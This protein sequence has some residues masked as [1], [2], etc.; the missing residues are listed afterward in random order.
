MKDLTH[1]DAENLWKT[2][3][4]NGNG[5]LSLAEI[6][7]AIIQS[8][9]QYA[10]RKP[11]IMRAYKATDASKDGFVDRKEFGRLM[12]YLENYDR[13][14]TQFQKLDKDGDHRVDFAEFSKGWKSLGLDGDSAR[15]TFDQIDKN[16]G[17]YVLFD[18][19]CAALASKKMTK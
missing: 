19:F 4:Y 5:I 17:G 15:S 18:E 9:P 13:F 2:F 8:F 7:R 14:Y 6:D 1:D 3:D 16:K 12:S 11:V 10:S